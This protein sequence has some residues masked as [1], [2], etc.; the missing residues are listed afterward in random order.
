[1]AEGNEKKRV[2]LRGYPFPLEKCFGKESQ[3]NANL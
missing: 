3:K 2:K 1:M